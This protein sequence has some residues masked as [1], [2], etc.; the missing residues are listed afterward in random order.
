MYWRVICPSW[1][2]C[3]FDMNQSSLLSFLLWQ[4][5]LA[6]NFFKQ[7][8]VAIKLHTCNDFLTWFKKISSCSSVH[9]LE[10]S[11]TDL[12]MIEYCYYILSSWLKQNVK[13]SLLLLFFFFYTTHVSYR[14]IKKGAPRRDA[15]KKFFFCND[16]MICVY[17]SPD[18]RV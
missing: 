12:D 18:D 10:P 6:E 9:F 16:S 17:A 13:I 11:C 2:Y 7:K 4:K 8:S 5:N 3:P 15:T 14:N 1:K